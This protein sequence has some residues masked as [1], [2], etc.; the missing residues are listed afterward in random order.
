MTLKEKF[1]M[2]S[3]NYFDMTSIEQEKIINRITQL[4]GKALEVKETHRPNPPNVI[5]SVTLN[6]EVFSEWK[7]SVESFILKV[8]GENSHFYRNFQKE[9]KY[10]SKNHVDAGV[11]IL[12]SIRESIQQGD[13]PITDTNRN[14][15]I[16]AF[17]GGGG[18][19]GGGLGGGRG[20]DGGSVIIGIPPEQIG[21]QHV[22][23]PHRQYW[24]M[25]LG[26]FGK[27][28]LDHIV[29][30]VVVGVL[31]AIILIWLKLNK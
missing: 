18:G 14:P 16:N 9:V 1:P 31:V 5:S 20:G 12:M 27:W 13:L 10:E 8:A 19:G 21:I 28:L 3:K 6:K 30:E 24:G 2:T 26:K 4:I 22:K 25:L 17:G 29:A 15:N 23:S 7:N 11:G